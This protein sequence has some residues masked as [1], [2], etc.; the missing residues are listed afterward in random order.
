VGAFFRAGRADPIQ[1]AL[2]PTVGS[3][4]AGHFH[5]QR[6]YEEPLAPRS[7]QDRRGWSSNRS[8]VT[9]LVGTASGGVSPGRAG[10]PGVWIAVAALAVMTA[11]CS[12][13]SG[14]TSAITSTMTTGPIIAASAVS[15]VLTSE[16]PLV[17]SAQSIK[18]VGPSGFIRG[19][20]SVN[21]D[22]WTTE[23]NSQAK[24]DNLP[25]WSRLIAGLGINSTKTVVVYDDGELIFASRIRFLLY[26]FGVHKTLLVNGGWPALRHLVVAGKLSEQATS[27]T[28]V[29]SSFTVKVTNQPIPMIGRSE[30]AATLHH[31]GVLLVDVRTPA[32]YDG[33]QLLPPVTRG[34]HIPGAINLPT[35]DLFVPGNPSMLMGRTGLLGV[36]HAHGLLPGD[37]IIVYCHDGARSSLVA[38]ALKQSG[39]PSVGLYYLSYADWQLDP[40]LPVS[41]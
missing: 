21:E 14:G 34:G 1:R 39:Y 30:V 11:A 10:I 8:L 5:P 41:T 31:P 28:P 38:T 20:V 18:E 37:R 17:L 4:A 9:S 15:G 13:A 22:L 2:P 6:G 16:H 36:F 33:T 3:G 29:N 23:S 32:E 12:P 40:G 7:R 25:M 26:H 24:L 35:A 19:S 27:S